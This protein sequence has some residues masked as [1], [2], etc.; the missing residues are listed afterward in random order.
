M[1]RGELSNVVSVVCIIMHRLE[2]F[3]VKKFSQ[4]DPNPFM[5][6][7]ATFYLFEGVHTASITIVGFECYLA[8]LSAILKACS[9]A[10][11]FISNVF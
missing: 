6:R 7:V 4:Y 11:D 3:C 9:I 2:W 5:N 8:V 10:N 1:R